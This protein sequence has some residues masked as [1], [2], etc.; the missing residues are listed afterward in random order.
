MI[1]EIC[2]IMGIL[3]QRALFLSAFNFFRKQLIRL[4]DYEIVFTN[5]TPSW[6]NRLPLYFKQNSFTINI[7]VFSG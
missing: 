6:S 1:Y 5:G 4:F 3:C 7:V 2:G